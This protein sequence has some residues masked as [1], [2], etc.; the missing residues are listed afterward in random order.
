MRYEHRRPE[1]LEALLNHLVDNGLNGQSVRA[2][3][4]SVGVSHVTLRHHFGTREQLL[5]E[6]FQAIV[7]HWSIPFHFAKNDLVWVIR[8]QWRRWTTPVGQRYFRLAFEVYGLAVS[9]PD[10]HRSFLTKMVS[11]WITLIADHLV[12][13]GYQRAKAENLATRIL[14]QIRGLQMDLIATGDILRVEA[15]FEEFASQLATE[16][17]QTLGRQGAP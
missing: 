10:Q 11:D 5:A 9:Q 8:D 16:V 15:A 7:E 3:A 1:L 14:A 2:L 12:E 6:V 13:T 17:S 4:E